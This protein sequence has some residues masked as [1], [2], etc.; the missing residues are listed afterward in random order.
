MAI[1][2]RKVEIWLDLAATNERRGQP[3][4]WLSSQVSPFPRSFIVTDM[5]FSMISKDTRLIWSI[6]NSSD[7]IFV[8]PSLL[9]PLHDAAHELNLNCC[10]FLIESDIYDVDC[11]A[12]GSV[13]PLMVV[14][15]VADRND[16]ATAVA[17][18]FLERGANPNALSNN[19][20]TP[21][22]LA[23]NS[24]NYSLANLLL[25]KGAVPKYASINTSEYLHQ[26]V[27]CKH[28]EMIWR[29]TMLGANL[30]QR[31]KFGYTPL[32]IAV[33][34]NYY[35]GV[36]FFLD[37]A[38]DQCTNLINFQLNDGSTCIH[39]AASSGFDL[40]LKLLINRGGNCNLTCALFSTTVRPK[41]HPI[42]CAV[43]HDRDNCVR[44]LLP[45]VDRSVLDE[46]VLDPVMAAVI[47]GSSNCLDLL[48][49]AGYPVN[50]PLGEIMY[51]YINPSYLEPIF[52]CKRLFTP[53]YEAICKGNYTSAEKLI[54]AGAEMTYTNHY[55]S[56]FLYA[57]QNCN[58]DILLRF[59]LNN[60]D[61]NAMS[62]ARKCDVPDAL[63]IS[64][65]RFKWH[66][67]V[68]LLISGLDPAI[69]NWCKCKNG[70][71]SLLD[72]ILATHDINTIQELLQML[73]LFSPGIPNCC[74][75]VANVVM[76]EPKIPTLMHLCRLAVRKNFTTSQL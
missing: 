14:C 42:C 40:I 23:M 69:K 38:R 74:R 54:K 4:G 26:A 19:L 3:V 2:K 72:D 59:L 68:V 44:L 71:Y 63:I 13:T 39:F 1:S 36:T 22:D 56:P 48:L 43:L 52:G 15:T 12:N 5:A 46:S 21:F 41:L 53:L 37:A 29:L 50:I 62:D 7:D 55:H 10:K 57:L 45:H 51:T 9:T 73:V 64:L 17:Q 8:K 66:R 60:V 11:R 47:A 67:L 34:A 33:K 25:R 20:K 49:D 70:G 6:S 58:D 75:E 61:I 16:E 32:M 31:D 18:Y 65:S 35:S 28:T 76:S 27:R 24:K 30:F